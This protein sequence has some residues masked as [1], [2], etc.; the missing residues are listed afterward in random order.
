MPS[1]ASAGLVVAAALTAAVFGAWGQD[2]HDRVGGRVVPGTVVLTLSAREDRIA[3]EAWADAVRQR[4]GG[5]LRIAVKSAGAAQEGGA[6]LVLVPVAD[7]HRQGL[8]AADGLVAPMVLDSYPLQA[9]VLR[10]PAARRALAELSGRRSTGVALLPGPLQRIMTD[11]KPLLAASDLRGETLSFRPGAI[12]SATLRALGARPRRRPPTSALDLTDGVEQSLPGII[13]D[14]YAF[15]T[16]GR[17]VALNLVLWPRVSAVMMDARGYRRLSPEQRAVL[18]R[19]GAEAVS[20]AARE[21]AHADTRALA[22]LCRPPHDDD[23]LF[24]LVWLTPSGVGSI[25]RAVR[26]VRDRVSDDPAARAII[27]A[28]DAARPTMPPARA[29]VCRRRAARP[30]NASRPARVRVVGELRRTDPRQWSG[31]RLIL[32]G[33]MLFRDRPI[34]RVMSL[35]VRLGRGELRAWVSVT[36]APG[37]GGHHWDGP[38][39]VFK[40]TRRLRRYRHATVRFHGWTPASSNDR[41]AAVIATDASIGLR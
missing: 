31:R 13:S 23:A 15:V 32:R 12:G 28:A 20:A 41:L 33:P 36:I 2:D 29:L 25:R 19:A 35:H 14:G 10:S 5:R 30:F 40:T 39:V 26:P 38:G 34:R 16:P 7:L 6:D 18:A 8:T 37:R 22:Q 21:L 3:A 27:R 4:S 11:G 17:T 1:T 9:A 24:Q